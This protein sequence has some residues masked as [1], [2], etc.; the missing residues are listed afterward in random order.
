MRNSNIQLNTYTF[1]SLGIRPFREIMF[2]LNTVKTFNF[3]KD[4]MHNYNLRSL[5]I[6]ETSQCV[7]RGSVGHKFF[8]FEH[9]R[10]SDEQGFHCQAIRDWNTLPA[11]TT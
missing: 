6:E 8:S 7:T 1:Q 2:Y 4:N 10:A 5:L 11:S 3:L 9:K